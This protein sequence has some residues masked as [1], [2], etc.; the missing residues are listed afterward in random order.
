M[1]IQSYRNSLEQQKGQRNQVFQDVSA[2]KE[3]IQQLN[4]DYKNTE[5]AQVIIQTVAKKTQQQIEFRISEIVTMALESVF[6]DPYK[7]HIE[8]NER[9]SGTVA[10]LYFSRN[11]NRTDE[12]GVGVVDVAGFALRI[13]LWNIKNPKSRNVLI[14]DEA[15]KHLKGREENERVI[16]MIKLLSEKLKLQIIMIHDE[17]VPLEEIEKGA[18]K[19]FEVSIRKGKS[20]VIQQGKNT[21]K[22]NKL[23][24][25]SPQRLNEPKKTKKRKKVNPKQSKQKK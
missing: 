22:S 18:D 21:G 16:Q 13:A 20:H 25:Q 14:L 19:I 10:D 8:I 4:R 5:E 7:F 2:L 12:T 3:E 23:Q 9:N 1:N 24:E 6:D 11:G 15:F 17:R